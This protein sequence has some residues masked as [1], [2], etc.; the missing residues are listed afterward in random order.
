MGI[1]DFFEREQKH[2]KYGY[3][4]HGYEHESGHSGSYH[5]EYD[6]KQQ[7]LNKIRN[8]PKMKRLII[9]IL[10]FLALVIIVLAVLLWP[11]VVKLFDFLM[12]NGVQG[13][14]DTIWKGTK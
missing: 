1:E 11:L 3:Q 5:N 10:L 13:L 8:N 7:F 2:R 6:M 9:A 12:Q 4:D 14:L